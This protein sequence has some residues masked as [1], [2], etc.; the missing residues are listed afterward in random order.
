[1]PVLPLEALWLRPIKFSSTCR[2]LAK[3]PDGQFVGGRSSETEFPGY[4]IYALRHGPA[5]I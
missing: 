1:M 4:R 2:L 3:F 5:R